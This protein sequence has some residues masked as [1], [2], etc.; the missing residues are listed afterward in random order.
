MFR[1]LLFTSIIMFLSSGPS[2]QVVV[3][4]AIA[5][6]ALVLHLHTQAYKDGSDSRLQSAS[7]ISIFVILWVGL[8]HREGVTAEL[9][10]PGSDLAIAVYKW[11]TITASSLP[12]VGAVVG[13]GSKVLN[14]L[15]TLVTMCCS[16][17]LCPNLGIGAA[18][19]GTL[20]GG[21]FHQ[22]HDA[23]LQ[24]ALAVNTDTAGEL[25]VN[26]GNK[27]GARRESVAARRLSKVPD[28]AEEL[29]QRFREQAM[30]SR[31]GKP[32]IAHDRQR[33]LYLL[34][35][36]VPD[37]AIVLRHYPIGKGFLV[38]LPHDD[39]Y[40]DEAGEDVG[41][42]P[43]IFVKCWKMSYEKSYGSV[44]IEYDVRD[45]GWKVSRQEV[46]YFP[47]E[48]NKALLVWEAKK[49]LGV[50]NVAQT[51]VAATNV[52]TLASKLGLKRKVHA[53]ASACAGGDGVAGAT[54]KD[55]TKAVVAEAPADAEAT[56][57]G[58][59]AEGG[60]GASSAEPAPKQTSTR[61]TDDADNADAQLAIAPADAP[62]QPQRRRRR[63]RQR[64][65][66]EAE[67]GGEGG[68][69]EREENR[70]HSGSRTP[71][72]ASQLKSHRREMQEV[73]SA[74][75]PRG[76]I[77][78]RPG[79]RRER[80]SAEPEGTV[81]PSSS[82]RP[83][84]EP[85]RARLAPRGT[86]PAEP[87]EIDPFP[88]PDGGS[89][90]AAREG[91]PPSIASHNDD[92]DERPRR[93]HHP[94]CEIEPRREPRHSRHPSI[95]GDAMAK[96]GVARR[97]PSPDRPPKRGDVDAMSKRR[98]PSP[99]PSPELR[100]G[101][102]GNKDGDARESPSR[103]RQPSPEL[104]ARH[105]AR[106]ERGGPS[107]SA[108][109]DGASRNHS[110][111]RRK[112][113]T[114]SPARLAASGNSKA[115]E[116]DCGRRG[117][118]H[119]PATRDELR[120]HGA[121]TRHSPTHIRPASS[122]ERS[123]SPHGDRRPRWQEGRQEGRQ[124]GRQAGRQEGALRGERGRRNDKEAPPRRHGNGRQEEAEQE[125]SAALLMASSPGLFMSPAAPLQSLEPQGF[126]VEDY[127]K[128]RADLERYLREDD[129]DLLQC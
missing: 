34:P 83:T 68:E 110:L 16:S 6:V 99:D 108:G 71:A 24:M 74:L 84:G 30:A 88:A 122:C 11:I 10:V 102:M 57:E 101:G 77:K 109:Q 76:A 42:P 17:N 1:K 69:E 9:A 56:P 52:L 90:A 60:H 80:S 107:R 41:R 127:R 5:F 114:R 119:P 49:E 87:S 21:T 85:A 128:F 73:D 89:S 8:L 48:A 26:A 33:R 91:P 53:A 121:H 40:V 38:K 20:P 55:E 32:H 46:N 64:Q 79:R 44:K 86:P 97:R 113:P 47:E 61:M 116:G 12:I 125:S 120:R 62:E 115:K 4:M 36:R 104:P 105:A 54:T 126:D 59:H 7:L 94:R 100:R 63:Q 27:V 93:H 65:Q 15:R 92:D 81:T 31:R 112:S 96:D 3:A 124:A 50:F 2:S 117:S 29:A 66:D 95:R 43:F 28:D 82:D 37:D 129:E 51:A 70:A 14:L 111:E 106:H 78:E 22:K 98:Q 58:G 25:M 103:R 19:K 45:T 13:I 67:G 72:D 75:S 18:L 35:L 118:S 23:A 123:S 39:R